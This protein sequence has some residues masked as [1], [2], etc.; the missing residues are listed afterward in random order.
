M[1]QIDKI[2]A[3]EQGE[4][5]EEETIQLFEELVES[6]LAWS[7]QGHYGRTAKSLIDAGLIP[8][9]QGWRA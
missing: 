6:G 4:L 7:L 3:Y 8:A 5:T 2:I 9:P 1:N